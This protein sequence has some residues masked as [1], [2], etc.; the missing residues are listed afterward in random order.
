MKRIVISGAR[1]LVA[2][3]LAMLLLAE[4]DAQLLLISTHPESI[5]ERYSCFSHRVSC[6]TLDSFARHVTAGNMDYDICIHTAFAR[7]SNG[8]LIVKSI[9]F[10]KKLL[11]ILKTTK[12]KAFVNISS[13][14]VYGKLTKPLWTE[15]TP[16]EPDYLYAMGKYTSEVVTE[17]IL[18]G[19]SI[20]WTNIRLCSV[21]ENARFIRI[22]VQNAI[23]GR[24]IILTAPNQYCSFI[25][26][27]DVA[28]GL[29]SFIDYFEH[30]TLKQTYNLG[31]NLFISIKEI[32][33]MVKEIGEK[34]YGIREIHITEE[35][36]GCTTQIGMDA[37]SFMKDFDW[38]PNYS[39]EDMINSLY[40]MLLS[41]DGGDTRF[42]LN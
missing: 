25:D 4:T 19:T 41:P 29:T 8:N 22:F 33:W 14:S 21:C 6:H 9:E 23:E 5:A 18:S 7:S 2:T 36:S 28:A 3:E 13:Q 32:A 24:P 16:L 12:L 20:Q 17:C 38:T 39:M 15:D 34:N 30:K 35:N 26:V 1:G 40:K 11:R 27:R 31:A 10:Q 42:H 37:S